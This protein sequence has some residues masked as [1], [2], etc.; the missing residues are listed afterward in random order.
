MYATFDK[1]VTASGKLSAS[2]RDDRLR[3]VR[4]DRRQ[5]RDDAHRHVADQRRPGASKNLGARDRAHGHVRRRRG[6]GRSS[7]GT[8]ARRDRGRGRDRRPA[9]DAVLEPLPAQPL[10]ELR[11]REHRHRGEPA[12]HARGAVVA[13]SR[14]RRARRRRRPARRSSRARSTSTTASGTRTGRRG[15]RTRCSTRQTPARWSTA[16]SSSTAT[17]AGSRA[18]RRRATRTS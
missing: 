16:S 17:A 6:R 4:H 15:R 11:V 7:S 10:S 3:E 14:F 8:Q 5:D 2:G 9:D 18:G 12:V 1:P 13:S